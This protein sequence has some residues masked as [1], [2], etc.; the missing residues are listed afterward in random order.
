MEIALLKNWLLCKIHK[1][2]HGR[3]MRIDWVLQ[4]RSHLI[5]DSV[6]IDYNVKGYHID[7]NPKGLH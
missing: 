2:K 5:D 6:S 1:G 4:N 3:I 7:I